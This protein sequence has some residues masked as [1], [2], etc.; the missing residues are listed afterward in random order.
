MLLKPMADCAQLIEL[1]RTWT[2]TVTLSLMLLQLRMEDVEMQEI[3]RDWTVRGN[4]QKI[5]SLLFVPR[6]KIT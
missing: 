5:A 1:E 4:S 2:E 6:E 3:L